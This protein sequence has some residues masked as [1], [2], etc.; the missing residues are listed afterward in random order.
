MSELGPVTL[1]HFREHTL[2]RSLGA[3]LAYTSSSIPLIT[4]MG[5]CMCGMGAGGTPSKLFGKR[6]SNNGAPQEYSNQGKGRRRDDDYSR[7]NGDKGGSDDRKGGGDGGD[8]GGNEQDKRKRASK[9]MGR[10]ALYVFVD[11]VKGIQHDGSLRLIFVTLD[12]AASS[13]KESMRNALSQAFPEGKPGPR[14]STLEDTSLS[15]IG[16]AVTNLRDQTK[17]H[18]AD[19]SFFDF[20]SLSSINQVAELA[21]KEHSAMALFLVS[22]QGILIA[23]GVLLP[24]W[25]NSTNDVIEVPLMDDKHSHEFA[26]SVLLREATAKEQETAPQIFDHHGPVRDPVSPKNRVIPSEKS[27]RLFVLPHFH[28]KWCD[29]KRQVCTAQG[30]VRELNRIGIICF[31]TGV[32][33]KQELT[34][35]WYRSLV[36]EELPHSED[37]T[38]Q[39]TVHQAD[40]S[41]EAAQH[42]RFDDRTGLWFSRID[43]LRLDYGMPIARE[44]SLPEDGAETAAKLPNIN[45][46]F[47]IP[48]IPKLQDSHVTDVYKVYEEIKSQHAELD[49]AHLEAHWVIE[50]L[51]HMHIDPSQ[52]NVNH[53][54]GA[55]AAKYGDPPKADV[56]QQSTASLGLLCAETEEAVEDPAVYM[57]RRQDVG[58]YLMAVVKSEGTEVCTQVIGPVEAAPPTFREVWIEGEP[59]VGNTIKAQ[60]YYI[61]G[62][63]GTSAFSW[64]RVSEDGSRVTMQPKTLSPGASEE[65]KNEICSYDIKE[66]DQS[67]ILK[68]ACDPM[69][70]DGVSGATVTSKPTSQIVSPKTPL[71]Q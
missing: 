31:N 1:D 66:E 44:L 21:T 24:E 43:D 35:E 13:V 50:A 26:G 65:E 71:S 30:S 67:C 25:V 11:Q 47:G 9:Q 61:G 4:T 63:E 15:K 64:I 54:V 3:L 34:F 51:K 10:N 5:N 68:V 12:P 14:G 57:L 41:T 18:V 55:L 49:S 19:K 45:K 28:T 7:H 27:A 29:R 62:T 60:T 42:T 58:R 33:S 70:D 16:R 56:L 37:E 17:W 69:R 32:S 20:R 52:G 36:D 40:D 46:L 2:P 59:Q 53:A 39:V 22:A 38:E 48:P 23:Q 6:K 8:G